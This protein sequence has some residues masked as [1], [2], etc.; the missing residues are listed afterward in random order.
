MEEK[1]EKDLQEKVAKEGMESYDNKRHDCYLW[2]SND[3]QT[4]ES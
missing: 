1:K 2:A 3:F 4:F